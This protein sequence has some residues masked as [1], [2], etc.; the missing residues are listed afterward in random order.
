V[1]RSLDLKSSLSNLLRRSDYCMTNEP[2]QAV[3]TSS[4]SKFGNPDP[5]LP[6][7]VSPHLPKLFL[8]SFVQ[9]PDTAVTDQR[10][11]SYDAEADPENLNQ[12]TSQPTPR[13]DPFNLGH[14]LKTD[15]EIAELRTGSRKRGKRLAKYHRKQNAV[16]SP[17]TSSVFPTNSVSAYIIS[18]ET[19]G[20]THGR[21]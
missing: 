11:A 17:S 6:V 14:G 2:S 1:G 4:F 16:G 3:G 10:L 20:G 21:C 13:R 18:I 5:S 9:V 12:A 19:H 15:A 8:I 7:V